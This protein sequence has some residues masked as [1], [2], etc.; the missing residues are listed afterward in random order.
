MAAL[1]KV[2][3]LRTQELS[4]AWALVRSSGVYANED[5]WIAEASDLI[6]DGGGVLVARAADSCIH[7]L[8]TFMRPEVTREPVLTIPI[9]ISF[10]LNGSGP[11]RNAVL[12]ALERIA[13]KLECSHLFLPVV[14]PGCRYGFR[15]SAPEALPTGN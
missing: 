14:Q 8:A 2:E 10:E 15:P 12:K 4:E 11:A 7:A 1:F 13:T 6:A 3:T 5:W 9:L